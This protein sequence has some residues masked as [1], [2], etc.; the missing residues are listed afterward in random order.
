MFSTDKMDLINIVDDI[1]FPEKEKNILTIKD[2]EDIYE[3]IYILLDMYLQQNP[4]IFE[5]KDYIKVLTNVIEE[6]LIEQFCSLDEYL[7]SDDFYELLDNTIYT[8][9]ISENTIRSYDNTFTTKKSITIDEM[10][11][12]INYIRN[13]KQ[14]D[15]KSDEWY[16]KRHN[17]ITASSSWKILDTQA[18]INNYIVGK[19][20][21]LNIN[22]FKYVNINSAFHWGN[23]YEDVA[24]MIYEH[25]YN[26]IIEDFG[27]ITHDT[28]E[29]IGAS[30]DGI[31]VKR[32]SDLYGR[33]LEI[34]CVKSRIIN[35]IPKKEYWIQ[36]QQQMEVCD[37]NE[38]DFFECE[39]K[40]YLNEEEFLN[41]GSF[42][43]TNDGK[44]KGC[45]MMFNQDGNIIYKYQPIGLSKEQ[46]DIWYTQTQNNNSDKTWI[47]NI[48]WKLNVS[49][50]VL[51]PRNKYW[52]NKIVPQFKA[53]YDIIQNEKV[54][55]YEHRRPQKKSN[56]KSGNLPKP[57][58]PNIIKLDLDMNSSMREA[59][60]STDKDEN[61]IK[62]V[63]KT[64][65]TKT[66][67]NI[68]STVKVRKSP[69]T[70]PRKSSFSEK[71]KKIIKIDI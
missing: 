11:K 4:R 32:D 50:C 6:L 30:P 44:I 70:K 1:E 27:C 42:T 23:K 14:P 51:V 68:P 8:Y 66:T 49:S 9:L 57:D 20:E 21:P 56:K 40:E 45:M 38:C 12:K 33:L 16:I 28:Y 13:K 58:K 65:T 18:S 3:S 10:D 7:E 55:G 47:Q 35:G 17:M 37:L 29:Y 62:M 53:I 61:N 39:F 19:C 69:Q 52:F 67:K 26:T 34:K 15:Q 25:R 43:H 60:T 2:K 64:D 41:D 24:I 36:M 54:T 48:Y 59:L 63:E 31:N 71:P 22:K 46:H 5:K